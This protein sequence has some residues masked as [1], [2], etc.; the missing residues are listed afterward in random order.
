MDHNLVLLCLSAVLCRHRTST[1]SNI[2][3]IRVLISAAGTNSTPVRMQ[4]TCSML[5]ESTPFTCCSA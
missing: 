4:S 1:M 5:G 2:A 3:A